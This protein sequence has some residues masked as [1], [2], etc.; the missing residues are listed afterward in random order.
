M[1]ELMLM[2]LGLMPVI[3]KGSEYFKVDND[4]DGEIIGMFCFYV[5]RLWD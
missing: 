5:H 2:Q 1:K 3:H 4:K